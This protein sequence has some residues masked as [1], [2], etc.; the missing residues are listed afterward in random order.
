MQPSLM[1]LIKT[2]FMQVQKME[3]KDSW[4]QEVLVIDDIPNGWR[5]LITITEAFEDRE[6]ILCMI[7][8]RFFLLLQFFVWEEEEE[9]RSREN[10]VFGKQNL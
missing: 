3:G 10:K 4:I 6:T 1:E 7:N 5:D 8:F 9:G 2:P